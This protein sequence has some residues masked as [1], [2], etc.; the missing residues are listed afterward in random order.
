MKVSRCPCRCKH[1]PPHSENIMKLLSTWVLLGVCLILAGCNQSSSEPP[2]PAP[3][4][5][6]LSYP[7]EREVTAYSDLT[8]RTAAIDSVEVRARVWGY[9]DKVNFKEGMLVQKGDV[10]FEIDPR[11]YQATLTQAEGNLAAA[12]AR[13]SRLEA[14]VRRAEKLLANRAISRED[15]DK[16]LGD[17]AEAVASI[18]AVKGTVEQARLDLGFTKVTAA[19]GG[20]VGRTLVTPGNLVQSGQSGGT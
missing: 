3:T 1:G 17:R 6:S 18:S 8:G 13:A 4:P 10:L 14:D 12:E 19:V 20:R 16:V 9:L 5:V 15:Y 2:P 7:I 11:S